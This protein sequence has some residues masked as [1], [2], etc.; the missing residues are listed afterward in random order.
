[1]KRRVIKFMKVLNEDYCVILEKEKKSRKKTKRY[2]RYR[3]LLLTTRKNESFQKKSFDT[4]VHS[5]EMCESDDEV[6]FVPA[7][8]FGL[9]D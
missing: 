9:I 8:K 5:V 7:K 2:C 4:I 3:S 1:M 6:R